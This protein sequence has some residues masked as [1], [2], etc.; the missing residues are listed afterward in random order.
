VSDVVRGIRPAC[1]ALACLAVGACATS[2]RLTI[3]S[4]P[5]QAE[6]RLDERRIGLTPLR[7]DFQSYGVRRLTLAK[8]GCLTHT[9]AIE[10]DAPWTARFPLD[11]L[12]EVLLPIGLDDRRKIHVQLE[13]GA[14]EMSLLDLTSVLERAE[15]LRRAGPEGPSQLPSPAPRKVAGEDQPEAA[16]EGEDPL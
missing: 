10:L 14:E 2:R 5:P 12:F 3:T 8:E 16:G 4:D 7:F 1:L 15:V 13:R 11:L 6:V 9:E